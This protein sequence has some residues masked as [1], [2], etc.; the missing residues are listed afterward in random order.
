MKF[1]YIILIISSFAL[2]QNRSIIFN[3][4]TPEDLQSGH[5]ISNNRS[6]ATRFT[7]A[8]DYVL[9]AMVFYITTNLQESNIVLSIRE[10]NNGI[11]GNLIS[12]LATWDYTLDPMNLAGYNLITTTDLC[13]YLDAGNSY[14][15][16][17]DAADESSEALWA[18]SSSTLNTYSLSEDQVDWENFIGQ[19]GSGAIYAEQIYEPPYNYGDVNFDFSV[20]VVDIVSIVSHV[21][22]SSVLDTEALFYADLNFDGLVNVVDIVQLVSNILQDQDSNPNFTAEDINPASEFYNQNIGPSFFDGQVSCYYFGKQ[23]WGTCKARFGVINELYNDLLNDGITDV[24]MMGVNGYQYIDDSIG[25]M[26]CDES[27][28]SSTCDAGARVL[29]WVQ[30]YDDGINCYNENEELCGAGDEDGDIWDLWDI[31]LR[32][33]IILDRNGVEFARINLTYNNPDPG[34]L[35]ECSGNYQKIKDLILAARNR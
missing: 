14:W 19:A 29:P 15:W 10:D 5:V 11:P 4:G 17:I 8:N 7:V 24:K 6:V 31:N 20:N 25:C 27:C 21:L 23:G 22:G 32:D 33:F 16:R 12:D 18:F 28:T 26:I 34:E 9:E 3:T 1:L 2:P 35:G 13:L 30:D